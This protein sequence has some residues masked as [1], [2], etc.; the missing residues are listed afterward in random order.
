MMM[1]MLEAGGV[2]VVSDSI[3]D[4]DEDNPTVISNSNR[5]KN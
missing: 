5:L 1:N 3:R 4:A 2:P